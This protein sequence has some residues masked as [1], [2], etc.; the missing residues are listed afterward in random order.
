MVASHDILVTV[1][2]AVVP[3]AGAGRKAGVRHRAFETV[4]PVLRARILQGISAPGSIVQQLVIVQVAH[5]PSGRADTLHILSAVI[6]RIGGQSGPVVAFRH[7]HGGVP[8]VEVSK[9]FDIGSFLVVGFVVAGGPAQVLGEPALRA[10]AHRVVIITLVTDPQAGDVIHRH[11]LLAG[12]HRIAEVIRKG[13]D[14]GVGTRRHRVVLRQV[15]ADDNMVH[16]RGQG[17]AGR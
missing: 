4:Q 7:P 16:H 9:F 17:R 5:A 12:G 15:V 14:D 13:P 3:A 2:A 1:Q 10:D 11:D 6:G 8:A